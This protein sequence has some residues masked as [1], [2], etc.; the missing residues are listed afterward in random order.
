MNP[1]HEDKARG[2]VVLVNVD[3]NEGARYART[4]VLQ[5]AGFLVHDAADGTLA[6]RLIRE[7]QPDLVLLDVHLPD[8]SGIDVLRSL[9]SDPVTASVTVLQISASAVSA[10]HAIDALNSGADT[11]LVE[12]VDADVLVATVKALLRL[13]NAEREVARS[14][15]ALREANTRLESLNA[16]L[17][18]S[19]EDIERFA[20][21][22]SHDLQEPLRT[23][24]THLQLLERNLMGQLDRNNREVFADI[25][26]ASHRMSALI[27]DVL[28]Y[29][30]A[31]GGDSVFEAVR[32]QDSLGWALNNLAESLTTTEGEVIS[33]DLPVVW[34]DSTQLA[35]VFQNLIGN[36]LK[37]RSADPPRIE[38]RV[39]RKSREEWV[40]SI[41]DNGIGIDPK[42]HERIFRPFQ[43]LHGREFAG[44]GIG[45]ALCRRIVESHGGRI[46]VESTAGH[47]STFLFSLKPGDTLVATRPSPLSTG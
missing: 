12:P 2:A 24:S 38:I 35:Q 26:D 5:R 44:T 9:K 15:I 29:S 1:V 11:Y 25:V 22:A 16:A 31:G 42:H 19:N 30:R 37:Y 39:E 36:A 18:R 17:H 33:E 27:R 3:D 20:Y 43:R 32:L 7:V 4:R 14:N 45:L 47:G 40:V 8:M 23:I 34:G 21:I 46:W 28:A 10:P 6:L 13:R 41:H